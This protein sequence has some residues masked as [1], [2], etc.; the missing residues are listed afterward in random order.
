MPYDEEK[1]KS[2]GDPNENVTKYSL[3][4]QYRMVDNT[5]TKVSIG[6]EDGRKV[7]TNKGFILATINW[8][9]GQLTGEQ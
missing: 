7:E 3:F 5:Y 6:S 8:G 9:I 4:T 1:N 2:N